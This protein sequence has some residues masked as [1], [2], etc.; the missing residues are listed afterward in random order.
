MAKDIWNVVPGRGVGPA[1]FGMQ[2]PD[3]VKVLGQP[4]KQ[5]P[6][7][8]DG[9]LQIC[10]GG[11]LHLHFDGSEDLRF[12]SL[13]VDDPLSFVVAGLRTVGL[14]ASEWL[15]ELEGQ[16]ISLATRNVVFDETEFSDST[17]DNSHCISLYVVAEK[18]SGLSMRVPYGPDDEPIWS[19]P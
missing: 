10:Y 9:N 12:V 8:I 4:R 14:S 13:E 5:Y 15:R 16:G 6:L 19:F 3:I 18:V 1:L 17:S 2:V 11:G 7:D